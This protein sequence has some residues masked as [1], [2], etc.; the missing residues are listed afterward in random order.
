MLDAPPPVPWVLCDVVDLAQIYDYPV[1]VRMARWREM[2]NSAK[3]ATRATKV[4]R[5]GTVVLA[6]SARRAAGLEPGD[7]VVT[8]PVGPGAVLV[9]R[10][11]FAPPDGM[12]WGEF[13]ASDENPLRGAYGGDPQA[14]VDELRGPWRDSTR[15]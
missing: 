15:S 8:I 4:S 14:Y 6:A 13:F 5:N 10:V 3:P 12:S 2:L 7:E 11:G 1:I 9:E